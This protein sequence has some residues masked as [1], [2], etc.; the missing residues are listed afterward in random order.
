[1]ESSHRTSRGRPCPGRGERGEKTVPMASRRS[2]RAT[3]RRPGEQR[4]RRRRP[5]DARGHLYLGD[6]LGNVRCFDLSLVIRLL[7]DG[8]PDAKYSVKTSKQA[9]LYKEAHTH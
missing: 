9:P 8:I 3:G 7:Q 5:P 2:T 1:M 4:A 6:E